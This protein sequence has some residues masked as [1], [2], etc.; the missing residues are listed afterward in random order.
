MEPEQNTSKQLL[1]LNYP[2]K[3]GISLFLSKEFITWQTLFT[4][5]RSNTCYKSSVTNNH[6]V[7]TGC[8]STQGVFSWSI[9]FSLSWMVKKMTFCHKLE[10]KLLH[11]LE[12]KFQCIS[13]IIFLWRVVFMIADRYIHLKKYPE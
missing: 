2:L 5:H 6:G 9:I 11:S 4:R 1:H 10:G 3:E 13:L 12:K 8:S 7:E